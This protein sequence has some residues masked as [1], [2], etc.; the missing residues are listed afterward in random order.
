MDSDNE[1]NQE[2]IVLNSV[3]YGKTFQLFVFKKI[4]KISNALYLITDLINDSEPLKWSL[5]KGALDSMSF[6]NSVKDISFSPREIISNLTFIRHLLSLGRMGKIVSEMNHGILDKE[7]SDI[8]VSLSREM[9]GRSI[10]SEDFFAVQK[11]EES[12][13]K[14][15]NGT[16]SAFYKGQSNVLYNKEMSFIKTPEVQKVRTKEIKDK[17]KG[18]RKD[19]ILRIIRTKPNLTI[20]DI[21]SVI[22]DCSEKTIQR[23]LIIMLSDKL[24][25]KTGERRWSRYQAA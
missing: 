1:K 7:I 3:F 4:S 19:E 18:Q 13:K 20:K 2:I 5:R 23:E 14:E 24:I 6:I 25:K 21:S 17:Q 16:S 12:D 15:T 11:I 10:L 9:S 8:V 22:K